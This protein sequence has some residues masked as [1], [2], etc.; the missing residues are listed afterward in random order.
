[1]QGKSIQGFHMG[2]S[3][4]GAQFLIDSRIA[5]AARGDA[6][7]C[8]DLGIVF[9][10]GTEGQAIDSGHFRPEENPQATLAALKPFLARA[11]A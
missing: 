1:M 5:D 8:F 9:S 3:M 6:S 2:Q 7:A 11:V 10:T 4:K